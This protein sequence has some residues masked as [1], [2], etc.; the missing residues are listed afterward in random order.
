MAELQDHQFELLGVPFGIDCEVTVEDE[1]FNPGTATWRVQDS[2]LPL[3]DGMQFGLDRLSPPVWTWNLSTDRASEAEALASLER[4]A[5]AWRA[6]A[7]RGTPG[8]VTP[9]R[10]RL[11]GRDRRVYG[12]P[13]RWA[14][15][16]SNRILDGYIPITADF[17]TVDG[18]FYDDNEQTFNI[19][20]VPATTGGFTFPLT[21][22][23]STIRSGGFRQSNFRVGGSFPTWLVVEITGEIAD[24]YIVIDQNQRIGLNG[25][26]SADTPIT[27]DGRPW[28][29]AALRPDGSSA[30][31]MLNRTT[32]LA[33]LKVAPGSHEVTFG[34]IDPSG[35]AIARLSWRNAYSS[36]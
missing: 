11:A 27:L 9:L 35:G 29:R 34:G 16:L 28:V 7:V 33:N 5:T 17:A 23:M 6:D 8:A 20:T 4:L 22:P 10:Y 13:R 19:G 15:P 2:E 12:R 25:Q 18:V 30:S 3:E 21:F 36:I 32:R 24:P 14:S 1:G 26:L 31:G